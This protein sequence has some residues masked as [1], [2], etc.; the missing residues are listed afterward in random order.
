MSEFEWGKTWNP[1]DLRAQVG[2]LK[3][4]GDA[5]LKGWQEMSNEVIKLRVENHRLQ[6]ER[7]ALARA[8]VDT[9]ETEELTR[10]KDLMLDL[11]HYVSEKY[12]GEPLLCEH[13]QKMLAFC[14]TPD[15]ERR[16]FLEQVY[17]RDALAFI[18]KRTEE[19]KEFIKAVQ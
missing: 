7:D 10:A 15:K 2:V 9:N 5:W 13:H 6:Q 1:I 3:A 16:K 12:P 11:L 4:A 8:A 19:G 14:A 17:R 18:K